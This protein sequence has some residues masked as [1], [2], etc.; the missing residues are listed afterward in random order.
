MNDKKE[1]EVTSM[2]FAKFICNNKNYNVYKLINK[3]ELKSYVET[4][5]LN[6]KVPLKEF[7]TF[8]DWD[9]LIIDCGNI[10]SFD[11]KEENE[12]DNYYSFN[13]TSL[14]GFKIPADFL[15]TKQYDGYKLIWYRY[16]N[17][18]LS[19]K[20]VKC[21]L[22]GQISRFYDSFRHHAD[23]SFHRKEDSLGSLVNYRFNEI[24]SNLKYTRDIKLLKNVKKLTEPDMPQ[25]FRA[26]YYPD[27]LGK[28]GIEFREKIVYWKDFNC[29]YTYEVDQL[30]GKWINLR[31]LILT[32]Y[33]SNDVKIQKIYKF[34]EPIKFI[35]EDK[36][37]KF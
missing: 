6:H 25:Y 14:K 13:T 7:I 36:F 5:W 3:D 35:K 22:Y 8:I 2:D 11:T 12:V 28:N 29:I 16:S 1:I 37:V 21:I 19:K 20:K 4:V 31:I 23:G 30:D 24:L 32:N 33:Y 27:Y 17:Y 15:I 9:R 18:Y 26:K 34:Y 10:V